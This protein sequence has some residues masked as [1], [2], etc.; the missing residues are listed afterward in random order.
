MEAIVKMFQ[1]MTDTAVR[2]TTLPNPNITGPC[3]LQSSPFCTTQGAQRMNPM[4]MLDTETAFRNHVFACQTCYDTNADRF[5][6][7]VHGR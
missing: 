7:Q 6:A 3:E 4:D 2:Q 1:E 5:V